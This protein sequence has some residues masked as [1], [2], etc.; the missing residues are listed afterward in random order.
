MENTA[1]L[2]VRQFSEPHEYSQPERPI[3]SLDLSASDGNML[4]LMTQTQALL[5]G[6]EQEALS[7]R[8]KQLTEVRTASKTVKVGKFSGL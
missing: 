4:A 2:D 6:G 3:P 5:E 7:R 1:A 8:S